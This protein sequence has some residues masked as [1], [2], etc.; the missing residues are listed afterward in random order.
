VPVGEYRD[1]SKTGGMRGTGGSMMDES[2]E[3]RV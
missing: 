1:E 3:A 2:P